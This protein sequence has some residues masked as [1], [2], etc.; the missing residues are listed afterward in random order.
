MHQPL[1]I[2]T[3]GRTDYMAT[4]QAMQAYTLSRTLDSADELWLTEHAPV[5]TLG[6]NR[7]AVRPPSRDDIPLIEVDRGGK[8]TY[9][10]PGQVV[11]YLLIDLKRRA[12]SVRS[13][14]SAMENA[15]IDLLAEYQ[16]QA[17]AQADAPGVYVQG[18]K[19]ASLGLR[20]K[21][22]RSYH[23]LALNI[24]MDLAPFLAID[25]CGYQGLQVTQAKD[26]GLTL[27]PN[28]AAQKLLENLTRQLGYTDCLHETTL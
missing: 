6:L 12:I 3:L 26:L 7:K 27:S 20:L 21:N 9:H 13:L 10:G 24:D 22:Q 5:Y 2:R 16:I 19:I 23:G 18:A 11:I 15:I 28:I 4:W 8:I 25:P 1:I 14:V 17:E